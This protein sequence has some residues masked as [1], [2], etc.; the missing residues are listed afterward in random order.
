VLFV[1]FPV[2]TR[3]GFAPDHTDHENADRRTLAAMAATN[4][5]AKDKE[6]HDIFGLQTRR[7]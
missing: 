2:E 6:V 7:T 4:G 5:I 1:F 3:L